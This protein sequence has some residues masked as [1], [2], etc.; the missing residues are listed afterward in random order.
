MF[1]GVP[2]H[3]LRHDQLRTIVESKPSKKLIDDLVVDSDSEASPMLTV[4]GEKFVKCCEK[5]YFNIV[6][7]YEREMSYTVAVSE[8]LL[9]YTTLLTDLSQKSSTGEWTKSG[10]KSLMVTRMSAK[11]IGLQ[12]GSHDCIPLKTDHSGLVK[13]WGVNDPN[14]ADLVLPKIEDMVKGAPK[15]I[16]ERFSPK[17]SM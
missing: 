16:E 5:Q 12:S 13:F 4:L 14:Y 17:L 11:S 9:M 2:N 3:G 8:E 1:F 7:F 10:P 6:S 15:S